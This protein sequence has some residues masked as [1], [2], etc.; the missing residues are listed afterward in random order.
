MAK[1]RKTPKPEKPPYKPMADHESVVPYVSHEQQ[2]LV[3]RV[4]VTWAKLEN[5]M[6]DTI[7][8]SACK[9]DPLSASKV[10]PPDVMH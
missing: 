1:T 4:V 3:G 5:A 10:D 9:I 6:Q 2:L 8:Q 7:C